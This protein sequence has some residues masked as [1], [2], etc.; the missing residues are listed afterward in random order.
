MSLGLGDPK[1]GNMATL[2]HVMRGIKSMQAK[3]GQQLRPRLPITSTTFSGLQQVWEKSQH[4]FDNIMLVQPTC[5]KLR[6]D[7]TDSQGRTG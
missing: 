7:P 6:Y 2:Q 4:G 1:E 3:R 5:G